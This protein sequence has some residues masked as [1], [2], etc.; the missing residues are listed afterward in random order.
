VSFANLSQNQNVTRQKNIA[1]AIAKSTV[2]GILAL[3]IL[4]S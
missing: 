1:P 4:S 3:V 2:K